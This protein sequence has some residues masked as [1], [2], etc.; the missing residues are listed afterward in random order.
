MLFHEY[1]LLHSFTYTLCFPSFHKAATFV[2]IS[3]YNVI[4]INLGE[5]SFSNT[6]E[7]EYLSSD[8]I[9][10]QEDSQ[11]MFFIFIN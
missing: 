1:N 4:G 8:P 11:G 5:E 9:S 7:P 3:D 2:R 6:V 10:I